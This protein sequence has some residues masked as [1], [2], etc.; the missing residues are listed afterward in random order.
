MAHTNDSIQSFSREEEKLQQKIAKLEKSEAKAH[1]KI[2]ALKKTAEKYKF[3]IET[4]SDMIFTVDLEG[5]FLFTNKAFKKSLGYS[6]REI[7]KI[8]GFSLVHPEDLTKVKEQFAQLIEGKNVENMEYRYKT[9]NG[10]YICILNDAAPVFD[11][12]G[13]VI[14]AFGVARDNTQRKMMEKELQETNEKLEQRVA[15]RTKELGLLN[16]RLAREIIMY[17]EAQEALHKSEEKYRVLVENA[18]DGIYIISPDGFE[19]VNPAFEEIFGYKEKEVCNKK[20]NFF[21]LIHPEDRLMIAKREEARK[22]GEKTPTLYSFRV[23]TKEGKVKHVEVDTIPLQGEKVRILGVLRDITE[24][25]EAEK[26][27]KSALTENETLLR[28]LHH[29]VKNNMQI[30]S[31]LLRLQARNIKNKKLHEA[32]KS[33][34]N[35]IRSMALIH[36]KF[37]KSE[38]LTRI[39]L[40]KYIQ[41]LTIHLFHTYGVAPNNIRFTTEMEKVRI[42]INRAIPL[43]LITNE[44]VSNSL[45]H[46]FPN[47]KKGEI[48]IKLRKSFNSKF[49]LFI[50][51]NGVGIPG[52]IDIS[53][54]RSLGMQLVNDLVKQIEGQ[55]DL[56][57]DGGTSFQ[58]TF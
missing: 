56:K 13:N 25:K 10:S 48:R 26:Q 12:Q 8:N 50:G 29:R 36:E 44:L 24:R 7:K 2:K 23:M 33:C 20:F 58:I 5:N 55:L 34:H 40:D 42:E 1:Q 15:Q 4:S 38:D 18:M 19:Y 32:F 53:N 22:R 28:E 11:S 17:K 16:E 37:Y 3:L 31:S 51:D 14:A 6:V 47:G 35:R 27:L 30:I 49:E 21:D 43:G 39:E 46:A 54:A 57:R 45:R 9:K 41:E 52:N